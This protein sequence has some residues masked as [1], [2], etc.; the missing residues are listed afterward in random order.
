LQVIGILS[1][2]FNKGQQTA[3]L[4]RS[5]ML[6]FLTRMAMMKDGLDPEWVHP[7]VSGKP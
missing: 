7:L 3:R 4:V 2:Q 6:Q 1:P 5:I